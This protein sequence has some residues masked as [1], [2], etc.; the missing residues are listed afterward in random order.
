MFLRTMM[1]APGSPLLQL[2]HLAEQVAAAISLPPKE[3]VLLECPQTLPKSIFLP[4]EEL[5]LQHLAGFSQK[6]Q[7]KRSFSA[8]KCSQG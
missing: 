3:A 1:G 6:P 8:W 4:L 7:K 5:R 2:T